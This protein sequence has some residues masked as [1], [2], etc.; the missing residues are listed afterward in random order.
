V[1]LIPRA[2]HEMLPLQTT[3]DFPRILLQDQE[4]CQ[5]LP[6]RQHK[7]GDFYLASGRKYGSQANAWQ[8]QLFVKLPE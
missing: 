6:L 7:F 3:T 4:Q 8:T 1:L 5:R 2:M